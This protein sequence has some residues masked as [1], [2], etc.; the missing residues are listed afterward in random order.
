MS[1]SLWSVDQSLAPVNELTDEQQLRL[2]DV[3]D[4]WLMSLEV[5]TPLAQHKL[6]A[7]HPDL[8][9]VLKKYFHSLTDLHE[10]AAGFGQ[11]ADHS[12]VN[13]ERD[14]DTEKR[15]GDFELL[16]E[17]GRGGMGVVYEARQISLDRRVAIKILPFASVLDSRQIARFKHEAQAAAQLHHAHIVP[18]FAIGVERGVHYYAMQLVN[19]QS[20]DRW[21]EEQNESR[22]AKRN[23]QLP[24]EHFENVARLGRQAAEALHA[25]HEY[26]I[27]HRDIKPS[28]LMVEPTGSAVGGTGEPNKL[29][30]T[31]FGLARVQR[32]VSLTRTGDLV[33]TLRYMSPEQAQGSLVDHRT[34]VYSLGVTLY[35]LAGLAPAYREDQSA[36]LL[37]QIEAHDPTPLRQLRPEIP[38]DLANIIHKAMSRQRD[39]RYATAADFAADLQRFLAGEPTA[40]RAPSVVER[41]SR[42]IARHG[43]A[44]A[45]AMSLLVL[46]VVGLTIGSALVLRETQRANQNLARS[47]E[48]AS[49]ARDMLDRFGRQLSERLAQIAG[50]EE[51]RRDLLLSA[52]NY[53][54]RFIADSQNDPAL[55]TQLAIT[56]GRLASL[57]DEVGTAQEA[58][59]AH[60]EA[61]G[62][63]QQ[64]SAREA[65]PE[66]RQR[67]AVAQNNLALA[68]RRSDK[69]PEAKDQLDQA[70]RTQHA[71][72]TASPNNATYAAEL[73][74]SY[75][76]L[77]L[78]QQDA[79]NTA[80]AATAFQSS[81]DAWS[82]LVTAD[83]QYQPKLAAA[84]S[85]LAGV[86][87]PQ[88]PT[89]AIRLYER[90]IQ[91]QTA[92]ATAGTIE[93]LR[94]LALT[95]HN[96]AATLSRSQQ[97]PAATAAYRQ[98][99]EIQTAI[100]A[101]APAQVSLKRELA[102]SCNNL[103]LVLTRQKDVA[104]AA[105]FAQAADLQTQ[106]LASQPHDVSLLSN[107]GS[108]LSNW[109]VA[110]SQR[111]D[112]AAAVEKL[113]AAVQFQERA[114]EL[115]PDSER[116]ETLLSKHRAL[117]ATTKQKM[118]LPG[119][120][121]VETTAAAHLTP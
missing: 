113:T 69:F 6:L 119:A 37:R 87:A 15:I 73:A 121:A 14:D 105:S 59:A 70:I 65:T 16:G 19:G 84:L 25:A 64:L 27:V 91:L 114:H 111:G 54:R 60:Q 26:G 103:G 117:L 39:D 118:D 53:Y 45:M 90:A 77:G 86:L 13:E 1:S 85:N 30:V 29:W 51:V 89:R 23:R 68:L 36:T 63:L 74:K 11:A 80:A 94:E 72:H 40:A 82:S 49:E 35:E 88:E 81:V 101:R 4:R 58:L 7:E 107:H 57:L 24:R 20:L 95:H 92:S 3:L 46:L 42:W 28:N 34:D 112:H 32:E 62:F 10:M 44:V 55:Q 31:D 71:L 38:A 52:C 18:V 56:Y 61:V 120:A 12:Q 17:L 66:S 2:T 76:N 67:L 102:I 43:R 33:G 22:F 47:Q 9:E 97:L 50:A 110:L 21:I 116:I 48:S 75:S 83:S 98:A 100:V 41:A 109:G 96:L 78:V 99:I 5:G 108:T 104:A 79:E 106:L 93:S 8:A 115:A